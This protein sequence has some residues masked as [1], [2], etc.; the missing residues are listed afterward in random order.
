[1][2]TSRACFSPS[3]PL[4]LHVSPCLYV[5]LL[6]LCLQRSA[7]TTLFRQQPGSLMMF[8]V[9]VSVVERSR[10]ILRI[11]T[12]GA[13]NFCGFEIQRIYSQLQG[14]IIITIIIEKQP[15]FSHN[16]SYKI[17]QSLSEI[18]HPFFTFLDFATVI[19]L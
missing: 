15:F 8:H 4:T 19:F 5:L 1:V 12:R 13:K 3:P 9:I 11:R 10:L 18:D 6:V 7:L 16:L 17:L 14:V 2:S